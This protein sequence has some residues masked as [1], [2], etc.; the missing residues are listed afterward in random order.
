[1][2]REN[3]SQRDLEFCIA[4]LGQKRKMKMF[5]ISNKYINI[6]IDS[7]INEYWDENVPNKQPLLK[8]P[9]I[10]FHLN[11]SIVSTL[12]AFDKDSFVESISM[13][14]C[15]FTNNNCDTNECSNVSSNFLCITPT[16]SKLNDNTNKSIKKCQ[17]NLKGINV[18]NKLFK[19][20]KV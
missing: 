20:C 11:Y 12:R 4:I 2:H 13:C 15:Y 19:I 3:Y 18:D 10:I 7:M 1:M 8:F 6:L 9:S 17:N 14:N 5:N 16:C